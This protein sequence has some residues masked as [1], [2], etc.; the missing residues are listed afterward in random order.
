MNKHP[1]FSGYAAVSFIMFY[2]LRF[3]WV[4]QMCSYTVLVKTAHLHLFC[5]VI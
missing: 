3:L 5:E 4:F 1:V 2:L